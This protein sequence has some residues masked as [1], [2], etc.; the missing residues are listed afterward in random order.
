M[1]SDERPNNDF[2]RPAEH[3]AE[4]EDCGRSILTRFPD[5]YPNA[6]CESCSADF[7]RLNVAGKLELA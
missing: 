5:A 4:C 3:D 7:S 2:W 1:F 6:Y